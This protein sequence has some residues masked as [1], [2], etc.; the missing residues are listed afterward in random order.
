MADLQQQLNAVLSD[1]DMMGRI[2]SLAQ[3]L[4][5]PDSSPPPPSQEQPPSFP[6]IDINMLQKLSGLAH[7]SGADPQQQ[8]LLKALTPYLSQQRI[9]RL[10]RAMQAAKMASFAT[11]L[12]GR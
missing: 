3:N 12:I 11:S 2:M 1:P 8:A 6:D 9:S 5:I 7:Q 4:D 10:Q